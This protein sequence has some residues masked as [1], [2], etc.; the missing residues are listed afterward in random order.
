MRN[1]TNAIHACSQNS[2]NWKYPCIILSYCVLFSVWN[3]TQ[4][5]VLSV[6]YLLVLSESFALDF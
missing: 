6:R 5:S 2:Q 1:K 4:L 3:M